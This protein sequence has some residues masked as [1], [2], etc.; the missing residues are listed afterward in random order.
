[1]GI[2]TIAL[3]RQQARFIRITQTGSDPTYNWSLYE[4]DVYRKKAR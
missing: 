4:L 2:T 3:P 1:M